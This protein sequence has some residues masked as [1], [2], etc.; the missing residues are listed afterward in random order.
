MGIKNSK[1]AKKL[2][3]LGGKAT[4]EKYGREHYVKLAKRGVKKRKLEKEKTL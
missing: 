2:G 3:A 1:A 4:R